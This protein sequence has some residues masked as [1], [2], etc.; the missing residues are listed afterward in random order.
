MR[1]LEIIKKI[2][3]FQQKIDAVGVLNADVQKK[4]NYKFRLDWNYY[5]NSM[6]GNTLTK[7]ETRSVMVGNITVG[8]KPIKDVLEIKGHDDVISQLL[9]IGKGSLRLS[10]TRVR[11]LH[12]GIMYEDDPAKKEMI[13]KWKE[14]PNFLYNYKG[15]RYDFLPPDEV[16]EAIHQL[17]NRTNAAIDAIEG[18]KKNAPHPVELALQFHLDYVTI[19]PF[20]DGNG[21]TA[22]ILTNLLLI[23]CGYPPFWIKTEERDIYTQYIGDIQLYGGNPE[24]FFEFAAEKILRSQ[25][26][27]WAAIEGKNIEEADD[28]DK[29]VTMLSRLLDGLDEEIKK[30]KNEA[31]MQEM[32]TEVIEPLFRKTAEKARKLLPLFMEIQFW[33]NV[34]NLRG[35]ENATTEDM[36]K[37]FD[38]KNGKVNSLELFFQF[39]QLKKLGTKAFNDRTI[40]ELKFAQYKY[41]IE[42]SSGEKI[43]KL[44]HQ[45]LS[46]QEI[47]E[48]SSQVINHVLENVERRISQIQAES[49][50]K[51][52]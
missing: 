40:I 50:S 28:L 48:I 42:L 41:G 3:A 12:K 30:E 18:K 32:L 11:D 6:E 51:L 7:E 22:R 37:Y 8:G 44:Y 9:K 19:H 23:S 39:I 20:Y 2:D 24:L 35:Y 34:D 47:E 46:E 16:P 15:E 21:R 33:F 31:V 26:L 52:L 5:S 29:K 14:E 45:L 49:Q 17:L 1:Y 13:G 25:Q 27:V 4:I 38:A 10:E 43:E 36:K